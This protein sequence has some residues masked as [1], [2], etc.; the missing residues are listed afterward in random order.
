MDIAARAMRKRLN[1][2]ITSFEGRGKRLSGQELGLLAKKLAATKDTTKAARL[3][4]RITRGFHG[5]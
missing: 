2:E 3:R 4:E 1:R 5:V